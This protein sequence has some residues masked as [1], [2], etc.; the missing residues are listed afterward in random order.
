MTKKTK[1]ANIPSLAPTAASCVQS[2]L[3][4]KTR[5]RT[6]PCEGLSCFPPTWWALCREKPNQMLS[7]SDS[8]RDILLQYRHVDRRENT[9]C[10]LPTIS[11]SFSWITFTT[12]KL[13]KTTTTWRSVQI[14]RL[15]KRRHT[16]AAYFSINLFKSSTVE[17]WS[18]KVYTVN[19]CSNIV[20]MEQDLELSGAIVNI[21]HAKQKS[22]LH[23]TA[24]ERAEYSEPGHI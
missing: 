10:T 19:V 22:V 7:L 1:Q 12:S 16:S 3:V 9:Y 8:Q 11:N 18:V 13:Q 23:R 5:W 20:L 14:P 6:V 24:Y 4:R 17:D 15:Y 21:V 2:E